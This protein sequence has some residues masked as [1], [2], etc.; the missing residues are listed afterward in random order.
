MGRLTGHGGHRSHA[1]GRLGREISSRDRGKGRRSAATTR[2]PGGF[3][4]LSDIV[5]HAILFNLSLG[6]LGIADA[7]FAVETLPVVEHG[8]GSLRVLGVHDLQAT[9]LFNLFLGRIPSQR[10]SDLR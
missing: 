5:M 8:L 10:R 3:L 2:R 7:A 9:S 6:S 1:V 4:N